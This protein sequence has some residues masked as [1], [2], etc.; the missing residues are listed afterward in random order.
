MNALAHDLLRRPHVRGPSLRALNLPERVQRAVGLG[1]FGIAYFFAYRYGMTFSQT[2]ASPFWFPDSVLLCAL[3]CTPAR[4][5]WP[6][7]LVTLPIRLLSPVSAGLP[8]WFLLSTFAIDGVK[9]LVSASAL[10]ALIPNP[11]RLKTVREFALYCAIAV[12]L[13]PATMALAG[14]SARSVLGFEFWTAWEQW[15]MGNAVAHLVITPAILY[16][17]VGWTTVVKLPEWKRC[18]EGA[19]LAAGLFVTGYLAFSAESKDLD[20]AQAAFYA[21]VPFLFWAAIRFGMLGASGAVIVIAVV[22]V[23]AALVGRG[24]FADRHSED[25]ALYLQNFLLL[26]AAPLYLIAILIEQKNG[27]EGSLRESEARFRNM[28]DFASVLIWMFEPNKGATYFNQRG[29]EFSRGAHVADE[30]E[31]GLDSVHP[32]D[33]ERCRRAYRAALDDR[34]PVAIEYQQRRKD[35]EYRW[36]LAQAI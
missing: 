21:P 25:A 12:V 16:W 32:D 23:A 8:V 15:F 13:V 26:R 20:F 4:R 14:A 1:A 10:R 29:L 30:G 17:V 34:E 36:L 24:P 5:W 19:L 7:V 33:R 11:A 9:G 31:G 3:L 2:T 35:G 27:A 28:A 18:V 6:Y 22:S